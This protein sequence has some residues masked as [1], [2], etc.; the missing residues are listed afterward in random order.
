MM[1]DVTCDSE[2]LGRDALFRLVGP[3]VGVT[4]AWLLSSAAPDATGLPRES[5]STCG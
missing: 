2:P 4:L 3:L 1:S 5:L